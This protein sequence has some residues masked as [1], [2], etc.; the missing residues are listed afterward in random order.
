MKKLPLGPILS[1]KELD[2]IDKSKAQSQAGRQIGPASI[3]I[4]SVLL[5][6][7]A[8]TARVAHLR[9]QT[10]K[11]LEKSQSLSYDEAEYS[12]LAA[13]IASGQF[14]YI[15]RLP[16]QALRS[17]PTGQQTAFRTPGFPAVLG[18]IYS[19]V[20]INPS[21]GRVILILWPVSLPRFSLFSFFSFFVQPFRLLSFAFS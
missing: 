3:A 4:I 9:Y 5:F 12:D 20:G 2:I 21:R 14:S 13:Q 10:P 16:Y 7:C 18:L 8:A 6:G 15:Q 11:L 19:I 1:G 17:V